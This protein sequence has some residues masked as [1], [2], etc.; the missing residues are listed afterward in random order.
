MKDIAILTKYYK[1]YNYGGVLQGYAL[2]TILEEMGYKT[3]IISYDV[4]KNRNPVYKSVV[5]QSKQYGLKSAANKFCEKLIGKFSF[6]IKDLLNDRITRFEDFMQCDTE[7]YSD[8]NLPKLNDKYK[9]FISGSDQVWNPNAVRLL[10]LQSFVQEGKKKIS[11]AASIGRNN[12]NKNESDILIPYIKDF[13]N[14]S[15]REKTAKNILQ[16]YLDNEID[17]VIDPTLLLEKEQWNEIT[18]DY[19]HDKPYALFYFFSD[20]KEVRKR[21]MKFCEEKNIDL[22]MIPYANQ[23]FNIND[24]KGPGIRLNNIGPREFATVIKDADYVFTDSFHGAAFSIINE[25]QFFVFERNKKEHVSMNSR[26]YDLLDN[27]DLQNRLLKVDAFNEIEN[28]NEID[29]KIVNK[30]KQELKNKS[31]KFLENA[32]K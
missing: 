9:V 4:D 28:L 31:I 23:R 21:A 29:Y 3:D 24:S 30:K 6:G 11:Y 19:A 8:D 18:T 17:V 14:I 20:S 10:Y 12:L 26:I 2:K 13:D 27:F 16:E 5:E 32:L 1:N 22:L 15:V 25:K 7:V